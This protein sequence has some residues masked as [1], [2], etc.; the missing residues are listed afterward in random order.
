MGGCIFVVASG[1]H[2]GGDGRGDGGG[3]SCVEEVEEKKKKHR[4]E[5]GILTE[6]VSSQ[7]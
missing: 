4:D 1:R 2:D 7:L 3:G 6:G 5:E